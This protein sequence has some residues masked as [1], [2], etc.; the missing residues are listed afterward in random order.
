VN[1]PEPT[2]LPS[3]KPVDITPRLRRPRW[4]YQQYTGNNPTAKDWDRKLEA[5]NNAAAN[6]KEGTVK[7]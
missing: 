6:W 4:W 1:T 3:K 5:W 7:W 2:P